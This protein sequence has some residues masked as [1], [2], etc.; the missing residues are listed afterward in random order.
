MHAMHMHTHNHVETYVSTHTPT[1]IYTNTHAPAHTHTR[2]LSNS[3]DLKKKNLSPERGGTTVL[4]IRTSS[5]PE[6]VGVCDY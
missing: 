2:G 5:L 3:G 6:V 4:V 1:Y